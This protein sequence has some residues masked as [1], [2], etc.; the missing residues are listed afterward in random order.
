MLCHINYPF[1]VTTA[2]M[3]YSKSVAF[4]VLKATQNTTY[5]FSK[6]FILAVLTLFKYAENE[7]HFLGT[8][9]CQPTVL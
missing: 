4:N 9:K 1:D 5:K 7:M 2:S 6:T 3:F 8:D